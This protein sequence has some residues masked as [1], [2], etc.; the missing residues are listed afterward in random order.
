MD[1]SQQ[2]LVIPITACAAC[3]GTWFRE[4]TFYA[5]VPE[6]QELL[7]LAWECEPGRVSRMP[8]TILVCL[9]GTR[10][11]PRM[12]GLRGGYTP[13]RSWRSF[14]KAPIAPNGSGNFIMIR[15]CMC[16]KLPRN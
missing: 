16:K 3:G 5:F 9:C 7:T 12:G 1:R 15:P 8:M 14:S 2:D 11:R 13:T 4:K 10:L 6:R